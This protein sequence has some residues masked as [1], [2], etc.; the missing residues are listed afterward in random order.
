MLSYGGKEVLINSVLQSVPIHILSAI[1]PPMCVLKEL[2]RIFAKIFWSNKVSERVSIGLLG[3]KFAYPNRRMVLV[4]GLC[5]ICLKLY[6]LSSGGGLEHKIHYGPI[7]CGIN[8]A[9]SKSLVWYNG[10]V[11]LNCGKT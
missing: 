11:D 10:K 8:I 3:M 7:L 1:V 2:H 4:L 5:L 6:M 9:R